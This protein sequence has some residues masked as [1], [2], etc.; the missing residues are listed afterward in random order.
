MLFFT[1]TTAYYIHW[2]VW[3]DIMSN[4]NTTMGQ[5]LLKYC[6]IPMNQEN[7]HCSKAQLSRN[8]SPPNT[9]LT[10]KR[11]MKQYRSGSGWEKNSRCFFSVLYGKI[12]G[13]RHDAK[14][15]SLQEAW[16]TSCATERYEGAR[17]TSYKS[18]M[19]KHPASPICSG[20]L[21]RSKQMVTGRCAQGSVNRG[22][23]TD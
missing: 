13:M 4:Q 21:T 18:L 10:E 1:S 23:T 20:V 11:Q 17:R 8:G 14:E 2:K 12:R 3:C 16:P 15:C 9:E 19:N 5:R 6:R 7:S 22:I